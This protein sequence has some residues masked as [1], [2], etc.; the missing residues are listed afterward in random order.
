MERSESRIFKVRNAKNG[1]QNLQDF[2]RIIDRKK[3]Y[4][5]GLLDEIFGPKRVFRC[6]VCKELTVEGGEINAQMDLFCE[7]TIDGIEVEKYPFLHFGCLALGFMGLGSNLSGSFTA[8][9]LDTRLREG[10]NVMCSFRFSCKD[11]VAAFIDFPDFCVATEDI[12]QGFTICIRIKSEGLEFVDGTHPLSLNVVA[13]C[14]FLDDKLE[15]KMLLKKHGKRMYQAI[16]H[17]EILDPSIG[18]LQINQDESQAFDKT[19]FDVAEIIRRIELNQGSS[20]L[21]NGG[22]AKEDAQRGD[23]SH[24]RKA[25][26]VGG[27]TNN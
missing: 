6:A 14:R 13:V 19:M 7:E 10:S 5:I 8:H 17:T 22:G 20:R 9:V 25:P 26:R 18:T 2:E 21:C 23:N 4:D 27:R 11:G 15:S 1:L 3:V 12:L 24:Q 16:G